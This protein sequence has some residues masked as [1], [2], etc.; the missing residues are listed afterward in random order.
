MNLYNYITMLSYNFT[1]T[2]VFFIQNHEKNE[3]KEPV[4]SVES[5]QSKQSSDRSA[6]ASELGI[7]WHSLLNTN[8]VLNM[9]MI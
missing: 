3:S 7:L 6:V 4:T 2:L 9:S 1:C 8:M 5:N